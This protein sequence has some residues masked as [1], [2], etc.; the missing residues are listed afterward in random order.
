MALVSHE[1]S[2][3]YRSPWRCEHPY[4]VS[5]YVT[6]R[7][8][9]R[10]C[11]GCGRWWSADQRSKIR[12]NLRAYVGHTALVTVTAPGVDVLP[13]ADERHERCAVGPLAEWN[14]T[15]TGRWRD[16]H[17]IAS[18]RAKRAAGDAPW[19]VLVKVWQE[20]RRGALHVHLVVPMASA[21][22]RAGSEAY[23]AALHEHRTGHSFGFVDRRLEMRSTEHSGAYVARYVTSEL[24]AC[25][26]L[27]GHVVDVARK[28]T[29]Q[30]GVTVRTLRAE[31]AKFAS[32]AA[33]LDS[34]S[35]CEASHQLALALDETGGGGR[36]MALSGWG[37][38]MRGP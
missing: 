31:R 5:K 1:R 21:A 25:R 3:W 20:Q 8:R 38:R 22:E 11:R 19:C 18:R 17:R 36:R 26:N 12:G 34:R 30:T 24:A 2:V 27:P 35:P 28:L 32:S 29:A 9:R 15:A 4:K 33:R 10:T 13:W 37:W 6:V 16:L 23:V 14:A 7:C